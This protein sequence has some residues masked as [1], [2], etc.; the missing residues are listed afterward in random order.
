MDVE[1]QLAGQ[2]TQKPTSTGGTLYTFPLSNGLKPSGFDGAL[3]TKVLGLTGQTFTVR[4][5]QKGKYWNILDAYG[6]GETIPPD[7]ANPGAP[8]QAF[9]PSGAPPPVATF[10]AA[11]P[12][13]NM[14]PSTQTRIT[15]LA[16]IGTAYST[17]AAL[18]HGAGPEELSNLIEAADKLAV[19]LYTDARSHEPGATQAPIAPVAVEPQAVA[20]FVAAEAGAPAVQVGTEGIASTEDF[21]A[22]PWT[23]A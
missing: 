20:A 5:E 3:A 9:A 2:I 15:K 19:K 22:L 16:V 4:L 14:T 21:A 17:V 8:V 10:P 11:E 18:F 12:T 1:V 23:A 13:E 7:F 6:P